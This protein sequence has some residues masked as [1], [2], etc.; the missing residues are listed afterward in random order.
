[1]PLIARENEV[2]GSRESP[3]DEIA[4]ADNAFWRGHS[5][6]RTLMRVK[7]AYCTGQRLGRRSS[8]RPAP[9]PEWVTRPLNS[10]GLSSKTIGFLHLIRLK[11]STRI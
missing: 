10:N 7:V 11:G 8:R 6:R 2:H 4:N 9:S 5:V 1:V 3:S